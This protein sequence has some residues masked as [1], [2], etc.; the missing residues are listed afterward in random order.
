MNFFLVNYRF[1][2][3]SWEEVWTNIKEK[4]PDALAFNG[5]ADVHFMIQAKLSLEDL[6]KWIQE[7][8]PYSL[9]NATQSLA[10]L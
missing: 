5:R 2:H 1:S 7:N 4:F 10:E 8:H 3:A 6:N 9:R